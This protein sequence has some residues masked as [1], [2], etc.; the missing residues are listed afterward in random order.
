VTTP[1][2]NLQTLIGV[3]DV[4]L[5]EES[6]REPDM[7]IDAVRRFIG[8]NTELFFAV[9]PTAELAKWSMPSRPR[10]EG[11]VT[12]FELEQSTVNVKWL[13]SGIVLQVD[14][15]TGRLVSMSGDLR[16][17]SFSPVA[18]RPLTDVEVADILGFGEEL[19]RGALR[20]ERGIDPA[21]ESLR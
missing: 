17:S 14:N 16:L 4:G 21:T 8:Q 13:S 9:R 11:A 10:Q 6:V 3:F 2:G 19:A 5:N 18:L 1:D 12:L 7:V 20:L 15:G